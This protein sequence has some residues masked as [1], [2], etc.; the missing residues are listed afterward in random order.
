V[1]ATLVLRRVARRP[2]RLPS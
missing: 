1:S 2:G